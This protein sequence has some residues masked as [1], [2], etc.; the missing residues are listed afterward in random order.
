MKYPSLPRIAGILMGSL[1]A[2]SAAQAEQYQLRVAKPTLV[3]Q[4]AQGATPATRAQ[5]QLSPSQGM[6]FGTVNVGQTSQLGF[7]L[8]NSGDAPAT[9]VAVNLVGGGLTTT[10]NNC[11]SSQSPGSLAAGA[12]CAVT[13]QWAPAA[14]GALTGGSLSVTA[15]NVS[16]A[17]ASLSLAG[18]ATA[19][20]PQ[21]A[22]LGMLLHFDGTSGATTFADSSSPAVTGSAIGGAAL[23]STVAKFGATSLASGTNSYASFPWKASYTLSGSYTLEAWVYLRAAP[24]PNPRGDSCG[25]IAAAGAGAGWQFYYCHN[26]GTIGMGAYG[27]GATQLIASYSM[28]LNQWTHIAVVRNGSSNAIYVNGI[29]QP[30]TANTFAG[31]DVSSGV[32]T[33][34]SERRLSG[35]DHDF[36]GYIDEVR[37]TNG[38]ARYSGN[39][40]V[41]QAPFPNP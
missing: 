39:F 18:S 29:S 3:V 19:V 25:T 17:P 35:W 16:N 26:L 37:I 41:P 34:G 7:V 28:P 12:S 36:P 6:N 5:L 8:Q 22:N 1:A 14:A 2:L 23:T 10:S 38:A 13:V 33:V 11:G 27:D 31:K 30:L 4:T 9:G 24:A 21:R 20:D 32:L 15:S 40:A